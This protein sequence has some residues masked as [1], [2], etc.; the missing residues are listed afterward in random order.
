MLLPVRARTALMKQILLLGVDGGGKT[1]LVQQ[2]KTIA[3]DGLLNVDGSVEVAPTQGQELDTLTY[4]GCSYTLKEVGGKMMSVWSRFVKND[5]HGFIYVVDASNPP[6]LPSTTI[7]L[8]NLLLRPEIVSVPILI[9]LNKV[10]AASVMRTDA[11]VEL[12][13][14]SSFG[15]PLDLTVRQVDTW[16]GDGLQEVLSWIHTKLG[17][18]PGHDGLT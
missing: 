5:I 7:E 14:L 16:A 18:Q 10:R 13:G 3:K 15:A 4:L 9:V 6:C 8:Y 2:I 12:M 11:I 17:A 1:T